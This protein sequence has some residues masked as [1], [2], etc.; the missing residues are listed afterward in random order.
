MNRPITR[1]IWIDGKK[2]SKS[3]LR[4][5]LAPTWTRAFVIILRRVNPCTECRGSYVGNNSRYRR[6]CSSLISSMGL[7]MTRAPPP[8]FLMV[9]ERE[10]SAAGKRYNKYRSR[11]REHPS[12]VATSC[13]VRKRR[14]WLE[15]CGSE[16]LAGGGGTCRI[17]HPSA[18]AV[19]R[20]QP[21]WSMDGCSFGTD[22]D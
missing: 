12:I 9:K 10:R 17:I 7:R 4:T 19:A 21:Q 20:I 13:S 16:E 18:G 8:F 1:P 22:L 6:R 14:K 3:T 5:M 2:S 15:G 11:A